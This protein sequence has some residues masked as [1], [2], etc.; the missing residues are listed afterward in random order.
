MPDS[1]LVST[2][3]DALRARWAAYRDEH[4][5]TRIRNAA[6]DLGVS[7]AEL[8]ATQVG[9]H[10]TRLDTRFEAL[11]R[12]LEAIGPVMALTRNEACV[13]E[14]KGVYRGVEMIYAHDMGI[15]YAEDPDI[16][17]RLFMNRW[18]HAFAVETPWDGARDGIRRSLQIFDADGTAVHKVFLIRKSDVAAYEALVAAHRVP[19]QA[20]G[21]TVEP[22]PAPEPET[23]DAEIDQVAFLQ[24][25]STLKD[26]H[27]FFPLL[28][29]HGVRRLQALRL[30]EGQFADRVEATSVRTMLQDAAAEGT[31]IMVFVGSPGCIQIHTGTVRK[32]KEYGPWYNVLDP[33]FNLHLHEGLI[34]SVWVVR[35]P[36]VDGDVN[37]LEVFDAQGELIVQFFGER[38]PGRHELPAWQA[39]LDR[40][41][42]LTTA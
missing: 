36:T 20:P 40:L 4:P 12:G 35:K 33:G 26:T 42:R 17:L 25:W 5:N 31:P 21:L 41:P 30:A 18:H 2:A 32:L 38:K 29:D 28:R 24:A 22:Y 15:V 11:L 23:P 16:D 7:E 34:D 1:T 6:A 8:L 10:V 27:D 39:S 9:D 19:D 13:H 37:A 14:K 3:V